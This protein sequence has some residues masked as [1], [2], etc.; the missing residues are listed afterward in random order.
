MRD[1]RELTIMLRAEVTAIVS[2]LTTAGITTP[3][4]FTRQVEIEARALDEL[5]EQRFPGISTCEIG[6]NLKLPEAAE[7][8]RGWRP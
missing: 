3:E 2:V 1:H 5:F 6:V 8:M 7:T 4:K